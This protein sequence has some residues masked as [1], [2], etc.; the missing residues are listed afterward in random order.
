MADATAPDVY[1]FTVPITGWDDGTRR[2]WGL[3]SRPSPDRE[4]EIIES[5]AIRESLP[6]FSKLPILVW[7][8]TDQVIGVI[9]E[10]WFEGDDFYIGAQLKDGPDVTPIW[11]KVLDGTARQF[12]VTI[13]RLQRSAS[14][15]LPPTARREPCRTTKL[16]MY[17]ISLC[18]TGHAVNP[19]SWAAV[20]KAL[21]AASGLVHATVDGSRRQCKRKAMPDDEEVT[22]NPPETGDTTPPAPPEVPPPAEQTPGIQE[23]LAGIVARLGAIEEKV[24]IVPTAPADEGQ[25]AAPE[26]PGNLPPEEGQKTDYRGLDEAGI[27]QQRAMDTENDR[28]YQEEGDRIGR[29]F[30][31]L[32][33]KALPILRAKDPALAAQME[34]EMKKLSQDAAIGRKAMPPR[35]AV[36]LRGVEQ[37]KTKTEPSAG[38]GLIQAMRAIYRN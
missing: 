1:Q 13:F 35:V 27:A 2:I 10:M 15:Y 31:N 14:C 36:L 5:D 3:A 34:R 37:R 7:N 9:P 30:D 11:N 17:S 24:G 26:A 22:Q 25:P 23:V 38:T 12:S 16:W 19:A 20:R 8:H 18:P 33:R 4:N 28:R 32:T 21:T 6:E 29:D